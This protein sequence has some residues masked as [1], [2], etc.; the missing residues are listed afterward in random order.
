M[1]VAM[2][3]KVLIK[4]YVTDTAAASLDYMLR[5]IRSVSLQ[6]QTASGTLSLG[7]FFPILK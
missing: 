7:A 4:R 5:R 1:E 3:V 2:A 6:I